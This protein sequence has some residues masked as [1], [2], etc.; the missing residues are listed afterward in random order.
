[1]RPP[2]PRNIS[3][4]TLGCSKNTVDSEVL[5][6]QLDVNGLRIVDNPKDADT[7]II[8]V[9][10]TMRKDLAQALKDQVPEVYTV[11]DCDQ[12]GNAMKAIESA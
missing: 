8:S 10:E 5:M 9:G 1:M 3:I 4:I 7:V 12:I 11:G 6:R 2:A